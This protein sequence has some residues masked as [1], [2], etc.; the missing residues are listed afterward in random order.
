LRGEMFGLFAVSG[1]ITSFMGPFAVGALTL[2]A[3]SQRIG[4]ASILVFLILGLFLLQAVK[5]P[6]TKT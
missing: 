2:M 1:K 6:S 4:M 5:D 3:G